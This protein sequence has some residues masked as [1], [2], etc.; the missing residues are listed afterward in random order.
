MVRRTSKKRAFGWF[1]VTSMSPCV[2]LSIGSY[3]TMFLFVNSIAFSL[4]MILAY[5]A[6]IVCSS[7]LV[8]ETSLVLRWLP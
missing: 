3:V 8:C 2:V 5:G 1:T 7:L 6:D 4:R